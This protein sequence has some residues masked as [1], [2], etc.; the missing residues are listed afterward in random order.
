MLRKCVICIVMCVVVCYV[1]AKEA[2][3]PGER[4]CMKYGGLCVLEG[5]CREGNL[6]RTQGLCQTEPKRMECCH[7]LPKT[8]TGCH[9][10]GG[11]CFPGSY[12]CQRQISADD[13]IEGE[14]CCLL[15]H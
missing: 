4:E 3:S 12:R 8:A 5:T 6:A 1:E 11:E 7:G 13:C 15:T 14:T 10:Q 2:Y 9:A